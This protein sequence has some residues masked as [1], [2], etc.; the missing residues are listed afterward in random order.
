MNREDCSN[1]C[2]Q[3]V[4][5]QSISC[6]LTTR[7]ES[8]VINISHCEKMSDD[9]GPRPAERVVCY[10]KC[11]GTSWK[12]SDWTEVSCLIDSYSGNT[13]HIY[14]IQTLGHFLIICD[15]KNAKGASVV[16]CLWPQTCNCKLFKAVSSNLSWDQK[17]FNC[18]EA[19]HLA[20]ER[21]V[22]LSRCTHWIFCIC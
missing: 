12:Y 10:G 7:Y 3:G 19:V 22:I 5:K 9:I 16:K 13:N 1:K 17:N 18:K 14:N 8:S 20:Y 6:T 21:S 4:A 2:G 11:R 15:I